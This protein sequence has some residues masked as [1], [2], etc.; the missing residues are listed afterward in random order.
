MILGLE[1]AF[2][3]QAF[4]AAGSIGVAAA[5]VGYF[6][7]LRRQTFAAH[8]LSHMGF[9]G[10]AG[11]IV[12]GLSAYLGL[13]VFSLCAGIALALAG[14]RLRQRDVG[15]GMV[16][17]FALGLGVLFLSIYTSNAQS[18][19]SILFGSIVGITAAQARLSL[20]VAALVLVALG[21][22]Y[23]PLCL[24]S[25]NPDMARTRG[26]SVARLDVLFALL[27]AA[28]VAV[29]VPVIGALL[30]FAF[31]VGPAAAAQAFTRQLGAGVLLAMLLGL[32]VAWAG[33][34]ASYT[35]GWPASTWIA[36][37]SFALFLLA[38]GWRALRD[39]RA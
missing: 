19:M 36:S 34:A 5:A 18:A 15:I 31:L 29:A 20:L 17:M 12:L 27:L 4:V 39:S 37:L 33:L 35:I 2:M 32:S 8:A 38:Q 14:R 13:F 23:R 1:F 24:A 16:L 28:T 9:A 21:A 11:A 7:T 10:A 30:I 3:R 25:L 6:V 22:I 26:I